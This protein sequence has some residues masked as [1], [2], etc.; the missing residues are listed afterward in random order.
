M[1]TDMVVDLAAGAEALVVVVDSAVL[2]EEALGAVDQVGV[3]NL[4]VDN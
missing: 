4:S 1:V 2:A 3:G